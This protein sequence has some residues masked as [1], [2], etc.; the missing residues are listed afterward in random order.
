MPAESSSRLTCPHCK[1]DSSSSQVCNHP[2]QCRDPTKKYF[3]VGYAT[4]RCTHCNVDHT[5]CI[6]NAKHGRLVWQRVTRRNHKTRWF[7]RCPKCAQKR[8]RTGKGERGEWTRC[9][10]PGCLGLYRSNR[11]TN[12]DRSIDKHNETI[13][14]V[15]RRKSTQQFMKPGQTAE[16]NALRARCETISRLLVLG[17]FG[18]EQLPEQL[19]LK[20][21]WQMGLPNKHATL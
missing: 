10:H 7:L 4:V 5:E 16:Q 8:S 19:R 18:P 17:S 11:G 21:L 12:N 9:E 1:R 3:K 20:I 15:N 6:N 13:N 2:L 14:A